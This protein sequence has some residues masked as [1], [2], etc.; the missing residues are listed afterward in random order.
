[1]LEPTASEEAT[2]DAGLPS[3]AAFPR[4]PLP[5]RLCNLDRVLHALEA[6]GLDGIVATLPNNVFYLSSFNGIAH[7]SDEPRVCAVILARHAPEHPIM[8]VADYY[9]A[10]FLTQ[11]TW[12]EDIR[13][14]RAVMMPLDLPAAR[15]DIDH[16]IPPAAAGTPWIENARRQYAFDMGT[17]VKGALEELRLDRAR[18]AFDDQ[19]YGFRLGVDGLVVA[20]GYD[21]MMFARAIKT[22]AEL[23]LIRRATQLNETAIRK[24]VASWQQ[25][26]TWR[27]LNIAY[28]RAVAELGGFVRDPGGMVW[29]H[30]RGT[31]ATIMLSS[32]FE[33]GEVGAGT[34]VM[35]DCHGTIDLYCWDGGKTWVVDGEPQGDA[36]RWARATS[37][38]AETLLGAMKPGARI[39]DLQALA[40]ATYRKAGVPDPDRAV[41]FFHGL[42][43]S[44]MELELMTSDGKVQGG[45]WV[46]EEG[47]V[48]PIHLLYPGGQFDRSWCEEVV[49][50]APDGGR[51][52][53]SWGFDPLTGR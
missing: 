9:L 32:G 2:M 45:D 24:T 15:S 17:A 53:F 52:L 36:R 6:R 23:D 37:A 11:P 33:D 14:F 20:D 38:V 31:D 5:K 41:I 16:F 47:M 39:K 40:R 18:V 21:P 22:P 13:P 43:L 25:G 12:I 19:G 28:A 1:M 3:A 8:V 27:D 51:P 4:K 49:E 26:A 30:P 29:G 34:H 10:T 42:G 44:H 35:F 48:A 46:L 50:I 7:K